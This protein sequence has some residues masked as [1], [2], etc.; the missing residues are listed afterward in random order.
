MNENTKKTFEEI[1]QLCDRD[2]W[3]IGEEAIE[4]GVADKVILDQKL[5]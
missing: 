1:E 3:F 2:N 5:S 4:L